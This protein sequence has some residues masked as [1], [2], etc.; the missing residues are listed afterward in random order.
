M[1]CD[2][3]YIIFI[4]ASSDAIYLLRINRWKMAAEGD[5]V[6]AVFQ[7]MPIALW[8]RGKDMGRKTSSGEARAGIL[9]SLIHI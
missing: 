2:I 9:L 3:E 1:D 4:Y 7:A 5:K 6:A 8:H